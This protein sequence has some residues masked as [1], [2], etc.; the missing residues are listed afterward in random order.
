MPGSGAVGYVRRPTV[1]LLAL[2]L[3]L[4]TGANVA[5]PAA[6]TTAG[7]AQNARMSGFDLDAAT[8]PELQRSMDRGSLTSVRLTEA[9]LD[10]IH[11][12]DPKLHAVLFVDPTALQQAAASD[13]RRRADRLLGPLDG[14]PVLLK[15]NIDTATLPTTA[16]S[17]A[18][19]AAKPRADAALVRQR[20]AA[21]AVPPG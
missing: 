17:R 16:G 21:R 1:V 3:G 10:R 15:D 8:I 7:V 11:T 20:R 19:L 2:L 12:V 6:A 4:V 9:Y 5:M 14:I 18:L 13:R